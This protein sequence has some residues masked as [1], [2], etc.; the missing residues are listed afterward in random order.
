MLGGVVSPREDTRI[1]DEK[2]RALAGVTR[3]AGASD[4]DEDL[5]DGTAVVDAVTGV[6]A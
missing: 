1:G 3:G 6:G 2:A 5:V 4:G